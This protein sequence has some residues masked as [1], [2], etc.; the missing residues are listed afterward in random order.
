MR[1]TG[2]G[3]RTTIVLNVTIVMFTTMLLISFVVFTITRK[4]ILDQKINTGE[5]I[6]KSL[7]YIILP[8]IQKMDNDTDYS[9][10]SKSLKQTIKRYTNDVGI[11]NPVVVDSSLTIL[12]HEQETIVHERSNDPDLKQAIYS[13]S[14][15]K[16]FMP[17]L[18]KE[19]LSISAPFFQDNK[20]M[21]AMKIMLPLDDVEEGMVD[22]R[23][24]VLLFTISTGFAFIIIGSF[25]LTRYLVKPL[26]RMIKATEDITEGCFPRNM[27][28]TGRNEIGTLSASLSRMSDKLREDKKQIDQYIESLEESNTKLKKAQDEVLRSEKL[29]SVGRLAAGIAHEI[30]NPIGIII[31]YIEILRQDTSQKEGNLNTLKRVENEIMRIDKIIRE[32]LGFSHPSKVTLHPIQVNPLIVETASL[33]SHQKAFHNIDLDLRLQDG[34]PFITADEQQFQQV[35]I[36]LFINAMDAMQGGGELTVTTE[37]CNDS[38]NPSNTFSNASDVR[39]IVKDTGVG[40]EENHLN[41]IFDPFYTTKRPGKGTGLGLSICLRIIESFRGKIS[42]KSSLSEGTTFTIMLPATS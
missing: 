18:G 38:Q 29:A 23:Q 21:G 9:T 19:H 26:E 28:P 14:V 34:L 30:G 39:I 1:K 37:P 25:L 42:V 6:L 22:Y 10:N 8:S 12:S 36:N 15:I 3:L 35:M 27:E 20:I 13:G 31:G 5:T 7:Q 41:R 33:I 11:K 17:Y 2:F 4:N 24:I 16:K 32:L 40:I